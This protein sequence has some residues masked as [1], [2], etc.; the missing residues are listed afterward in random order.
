MAAEEFVGAIALELDGREIECTSLSVNVST[1]NRLVRT[2]NRSRNAAGYTKGVRQY[3]L[4]L[5]VVVPADGN[6]PNWAEIVGAKI[7]R[8][9]IDGQGERVSYL[10][11][12]TVS[13]GHTFEVDGEARKSISMHA[14]REVRE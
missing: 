12:F 9:P 4:N 2:M 7:T 6:E 8:E 14:M 3:D 10:D 5:T 13:V 1:G 11:C